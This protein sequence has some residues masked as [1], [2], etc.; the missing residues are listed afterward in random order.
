MHRISKLEKEAMDAHKLL[1]NLGIPRLD[2]KG[3]HSLSFRIHLL[4]HKLKKRE[5]KM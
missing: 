3:E 5:L 2:E 4:I 1:T